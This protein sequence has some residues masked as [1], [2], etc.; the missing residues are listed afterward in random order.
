MKLTTKYLGLTLAHP[1]MPGASPLADHLDAVRELEDAGASA[2]VMRSLFEEQVLRARAAVTPYAPLAAEF[3]LTP[4]QYLE[5]IRCIKSRVALPLIASLNGTTTEGWLECARSLEK[6]GADA[7]ELNFYHIATNPLEDSGS[8]ECRLLDMVAV[9]KE[10]VRIPLAVK[11]SPFYSSLPNLASR[12]EAIG[13]NGLVLFNRF[14]QPDIDPEEL[15]AELRLQL[16]TSSDLLLR[17]RWLAIL[18]QSVRG[19]LAVTG[20]VHEPL[21]AVKA[22]MAGADAIQVVSALL[23][24]GPW[25]LTTL[26]RGL[27]HWCEA[28][29]YESI[30]QIRDCMSLA[31]SP[32]PHAFERGSYTR[33]LQSWGPS[34]TPGTGR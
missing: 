6:A 10:S 19:S 27:E 4:D 14:Y 22:V 13:A 24:K 16:S 12:L 23:K 26:R 25:H 7:V 29:G 30:D 2:I 28:H 11:L 33:I 31:L 20:G 32:D 9:L 34:T 8:V 18:S 3:V 17:L 1:F 15:D 5:Q 21:D